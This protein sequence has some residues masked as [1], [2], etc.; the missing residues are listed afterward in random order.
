[1]P[2]QTVLPQELVS[3]RSSRCQSAW[4]QQSCCSM[5]L[6]TWRFHASVA[7]GA[8]SQEHF[9]MDPILQSVLPKGW[10][11]TLRQRAPSQHSNHAPQNIPRK[12]ESMVGMV[13]EAH[14]VGLR[15]V[16]AAAEDLLLIDLSMLVDVLWSDGAVAAALLTLLH[17]LPHPQLAL[18][19]LHF[20]AT[21]QPIEH[22][23]CNACIRQSSDSPGGPHMLD[24]PAYT[25]PSSACEGTARR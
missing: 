16:A 10:Y 15:V 7:E 24:S 2:T 20:P 22:T 21:A 17:R 12:S 11:T 23:D 18:L 25:R 19:N 6:C 1:M 5:L 13:V 4:R 8:L 9:C 3:D 14:L